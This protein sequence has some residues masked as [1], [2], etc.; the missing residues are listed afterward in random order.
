MVG[1]SR[2]PHVIK[3][4]ITS[5]QD[6]QKDESGDWV[7]VDQEPVNKEIACRAVPN[8]KGTTFNGENGDLITFDFLVYAPADILDLEL[9][10]NVE[11]FNQG[12]S[13][14]KG[15]IKRFHGSRKNTKLWV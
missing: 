13:F 10:L 12:K 9:N 5:D 3:F 6:T 1:F 8:G 15:T 11:I 7:I 4:T 14:A 2:F